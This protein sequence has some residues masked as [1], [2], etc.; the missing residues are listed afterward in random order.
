MKMK[1][2]YNILT[3]AMIIGI[4]NPI[5]AQKFGYINTQQVVDNIPEMKEANANIETFAAQLE[6]KAQ[7]MIKVFQGKIQ[8]IDRK[9]SQGEIS[10]VQ[11]EEERVKLQAEE[12]TIL[13][14]QQSSQMKIQEK[15]ELLLSPIRDRINDA[16][17]AVS[18]EK[19]YDYIF[20][21][22]TGFVLFADPS[23]DVSELVKAK[24]LN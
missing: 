24:L 9:Q 18:S 12:Q 15:S 10:P 11:L 21:Y 6:K 13:E 17:K 16:I 22:S 20:D 3:I 1:F 5:S 14:F 4:C 23:T 2:F 19:G 7:D 8:D